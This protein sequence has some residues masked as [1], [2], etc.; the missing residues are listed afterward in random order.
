MNFFVS[1]GRATMFWCLIAAL[2][3]GAIMVSTASMALSPMLGALSMGAVWGAWIVSIAISANRKLDVSLRRSPTLMLV[4]MGFA[5][6]YIGI[7]QWLLPDV[8]TGEGGVS[9]WIVV[10]MHFAAML[11]IFYAL[12]FSANRLMTLDRGKNVS[13]L[14]YSGAFF[15]M[16]FFPVGVWFVQPRVNGLLGADAG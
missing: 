6:F 11:G 2:F 16:W 9:P 7:S 8:T 10:P 15:L 12:L 5:A 1:A 13:F 3:V 14:D 4:G